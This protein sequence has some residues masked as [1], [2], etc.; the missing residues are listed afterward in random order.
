MTL[1]PAKPAAPGYGCRTASA[2]RPGG[3]GSGDPRLTGDN[4]L[5]NHA[6]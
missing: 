2:R 5:L 3:R 1:L 4:R 6:D